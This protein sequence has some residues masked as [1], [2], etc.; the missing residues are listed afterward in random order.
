MTQISTYLMFQ[1]GKA[2]EAMDFYLDVFGG[3]V[4][5]VSRWGPDGPGEE[6][7]V[8]LAVFTL[9][10]NRF[11]C[12][13]SPPVHDFGFTPST[14]SFV[15]FDSEAELDR[16]YAALAEGGTALMPLGDYGFSEKFGWVA[17]RFGVSWQLNL[18]HR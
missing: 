16:A 14:S 2:E 5:D 15:D 18:P 3:E 12:F 11:M 8:Q 4:L 9:C 13:N 1:D 7:A 17:D 6:G 10:G